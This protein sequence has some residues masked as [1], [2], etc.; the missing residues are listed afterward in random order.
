MELGGDGIDDRTRSAAAGWRAG[1]ATG[2]THQLGAA[3]TAERMTREGFDDRLHIAHLQLLRALS[4]RAPR[5]SDEVAFDEAFGSTGQFGNVT[6][7]VFNGG[8][9]VR[10]LSFERHM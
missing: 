7:E 3:I 6:S 4:V 8:G 1:A 10:V 2:R 5:E 9:V